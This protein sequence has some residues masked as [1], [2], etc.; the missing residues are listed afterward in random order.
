MVMFC[1]VISK[2]LGPQGQEDVKLA[3]VDMITDPIEVQVNGMG[4][5]L[6]DCVICGAECSGVVDLDG[7]H[8][9]WVA[10]GADS[11]I[12]VKSPPVLASLAN[13]RTMQM[14]SMVAKLGWLGLCH[15]PPRSTEIYQC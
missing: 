3:L 11:F 1:G 12:L 5:L 10:G 6:F 7:C 14:I 4:V 15:G 9:L 13:E 8:W 2:V